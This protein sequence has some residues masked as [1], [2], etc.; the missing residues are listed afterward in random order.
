[1]KANHRLRPL[2]AAIAA[3]A[4]T[5]LGACTAPR[6]VPA[7]ASGAKPAPAPASSAKQGPATV[8]APAPSVRP[9]GDWTEA[10]ITPG[11][12]TWGMESGQSVARFAGSLLILRCDSASRT[13]I[14]ERA[15]SAA[16]AGQVPMT[17]I[18][19][20]ISKPLAGIARTGS[21]PAIAVTLGPRDPLLDAMAFSRG[22]FALETS[23]LPTL[24][25]PSWPEI[26]RVIEDCR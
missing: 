21:Q 1:M 3:T 15:G 16:V 4:L 18:T 7:P 17:V 20:S 13:V 22:R 9:A 12:W 2:F 8:P 14:L 26:S 6:I 10:A 25:V 23:G 24:Y 11:D 19:D 5:A